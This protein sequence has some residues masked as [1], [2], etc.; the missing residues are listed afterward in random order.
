MKTWIVEIFRYGAWEAG[1]FCDSLEEAKREKRIL[2]RKYR[3][4]IVVAAE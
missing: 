4:R 1:V 3:C 2:A